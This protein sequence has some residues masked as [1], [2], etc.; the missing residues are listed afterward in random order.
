MLFLG[1]FHKINIPVVVFLFFALPVYAA[2]K[3]SKQGISAFRTAYSAPGDKSKHILNFIRSN[4]ADAYESKDSWYRVMKVCGEKLNSEEGEYYA[5]ACFNLASGLHYHEYVKDSYYYYVKA[6]NSIEENTPKDDRF[7]SEFNWQYGSV[8]FT[9]KRYAEAR[10]YFQRSFNQINIENASD[11]MKIG[12]TMGLLNLKQQYLDSARIYF[13]D[14]LDA[15]KEMKNRAWIG[16]ISGNLG[17]AYEAL[18]ETNKAYG[19]Y[20][21]DLDLSLETL[22]YGSAIRALIAL[23]HIDVQQNRPAKAESRLM[24]MDS[25]LKAIPYNT[26]DYML[27]NQAAAEVYSL[28]GNHVKALDSYKLFVHYRDSVEEQERSEDIRNVDFQLDVDRK[29]SEIQLLKERKRFDNLIIFS[30]SIGAVGLLIVFVVIINL[31]S[32]RRKR[33]RELA[34]IQALHMQ[35]ELM[36][37]DREMRTM[38]NNLIE[39]N[40]LIEQLTGEIEQIQSVDLPEISEERLKM[41]EKLQTHTLLTDEDWFEFKLLF[42]KLNPTFFAKVFRH[43]PDLTNAELRLLALM[44]LNLS[45]IEMSRVLGISPDSVRKTSLRLRKKWNME[46]PEELLKFIMSV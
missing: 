39:K 46:Q 45:T 14:A 28:L 6:K 3:N 40:V 7:I 19:L 25:I 8:L 22:Q 18:G 17:K 12:N 31:I 13:E 36:N 34:N 24:L 4:P 37:T 16:I 20:Q 15:A 5:E 27:Y 11:R 2:K 10:I 26:G 1:P 43:A 41:S 30:L 23:I 38:L 32:K 42:E 9:F 29:I 35:Q 33:E 21:T 44:K